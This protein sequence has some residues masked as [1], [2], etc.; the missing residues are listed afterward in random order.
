MYFSRNITSLVLHGDISDW[1]LVLL[2]ETF[3]MC[4]FQ[5]M[6]MGTAASRHRVI[7]CA[8]QYMLLRRKF[9]VVWQEVCRGLLVGLIN[10]Q[11]VQNWISAPTTGNSNTWWKRRITW[12]ASVGDLL[13]QLAQDRHSWNREFNW[14]ITPSYVRPSADAWLFQVIDTINSLFLGCVWPVKFLTLRNPNA[15]LQT[16]ATLI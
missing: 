4:E 12:A 16:V 15:S 3:C 5:V 11:G 8:R 6:E 9:S 14:Y 7:V 10:L 1:R 2:H 13:R